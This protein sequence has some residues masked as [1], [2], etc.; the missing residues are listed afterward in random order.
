MD[1]LYRRIEWF[2]PSERDE[3]IRYLDG[4]IT[5]H[6]EKLIKTQRSR[7][8]RHGVDADHVDDLCY[9]SSNVL[10]LTQTKTRKKKHSNVN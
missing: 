3:V 9:R 5:K 1:A 8:E 6:F 4:C 7:L 2:E 10:G